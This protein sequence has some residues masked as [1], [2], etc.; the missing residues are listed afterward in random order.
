[1][2]NGQPQTPSPTPPP[3]RGGVPW[4]HLVFLALIVLTGLAGGLLMWLS[5]H[6]KPAA[7]PQISFEAAQ[8]ASPLPIYATL[9]EILAAP[10]R[11]GAETSTASLKGKVWTAAY[12]YSR[13]PRG[14]LGVA[15]TMLKLRDEFGGDPRFHQVSIAV[16][17]E[18]DTPAALKEFAQA[19]GVRETDAWWFLSGEPKPLRDFLTYQV[20]FA[21]TIKVP[22]P[23]R[24]SEFDLYEHDLRIALIDAVGRVRGYYE[25]QNPDHATADLHLERLRDDIRRLLAE[26]AAE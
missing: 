22:E 12:T 21:Q 23:E 3:G 19:S 17:P 25:V 6:R 9:R 11:L 14:C 5:Q 1:M 4:F 18:I 8:Q 15:G 26:P 10:E 7:A 2:M 13:C 24:L 16:A 20:G